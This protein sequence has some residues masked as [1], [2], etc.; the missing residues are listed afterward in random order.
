MP[1]AGTT[2]VDVEQNRAKALLQS[3]RLRHVVTLKMLH[4]GGRAIQCRLREDA[5]GWGLLSLFHTRVFEYDQQ[6]Y[7]DRDWVVLMDGTSAAAKAKLLEELPLG[8]LVVKTYDSAVKEFLA[9]KYRAVP[10]RSFVSFTSAPGSPRRPPT[11]EVVESTTLEPEVAK[12]FAANG[13]ADSE[14]ARHFADGAR[15]FAIKAGGR[16]ISACLVFRN[17]ETVWEIGG[18]FTQPEHRRQGLAREV[19]AAALDYLQK[20][21]CLP[22]YQVRTDNTASIDLAK[23]AGLQEFLRMDHY[24]VD[25]KG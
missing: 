23:A 5:E 3:D 24:L 21:H 14:L 15:W 18:V 7:A 9:Q 16:A 6:T 11:R 8:A 25:R 10:V 12:M 22:R 13:Y 1:A 4:L 2:K 17:F 19:V 20:A